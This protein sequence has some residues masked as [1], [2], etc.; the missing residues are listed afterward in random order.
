MTDDADPYDLVLGASYSAVMKFGAVRF[1]ALARTTIWHLRRLEASGIWGDDHAHRTLWDEV[2]Y[3]V[4]EGPFDIAYG[5][6]GTPSDAF[7]DLA[8]LLDK[9]LVVR[10]VPVDAS[11][12]QQFT[13]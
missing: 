12:S 5:S 8:E 7:E 1:D 11:D 13:E 4:Q 3:E 6:F 2:C 10:L 9:L